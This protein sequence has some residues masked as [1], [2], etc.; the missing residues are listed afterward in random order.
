MPEP[1]TPQTQRTDTRRTLTNQKPLCSI[2]WR[3]VLHVA[4]V[5][6]AFPGSAPGGSVVRNLGP[7][8][9]C[10]VGSPRNQAVS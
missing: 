1:P 7:P 10:S 9:Q 3:R 2:T 8:P 5:P 6:A 4:S